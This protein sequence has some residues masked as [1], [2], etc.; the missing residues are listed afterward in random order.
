MKKLLLLSGILLFVSA[1][2][3]DTVENFR[4]HP[5][6]N[7]YF[8][9]TTGSYWIY[10]HT[11][12][13]SN[14]VETIM[15]MADD[16]VYVSGDTII[17]GKSYAVIVGLYW[18]PLASMCRRDSLGYLLDQWSIPRF[19]MTNFTDTLHEIH[20]TSTYGADDYFQML[21]AGTMTVPSGTYEAL[22]YHEYINI[23][24]PSY[25]YDPHRY[26]ATYYAKGVGVIRETYFYYSAWFYY[27]RRLV[28]YH[29]E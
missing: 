28:R 16:S 23:N 17:N 20:D 14:G 15:P 10:D 25:P 12:I 5:D 2:R 3:K 26:F 18:N 8:P 7:E 9:M 27:S 4:K 21:H 22:D 29:I 24:N 1:C 11:K 13:D 19:S 6:A